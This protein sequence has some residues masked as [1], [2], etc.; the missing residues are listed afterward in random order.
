[1]IAPVVCDMKGIGPA[2][3][4]FVLRKTFPA[5]MENVLQNN[6]KKWGGPRA[7]RACPSRNTLKTKDNRRMKRVAA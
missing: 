1:M 3:A 7:F 5:P 2:V 4:V 6:E